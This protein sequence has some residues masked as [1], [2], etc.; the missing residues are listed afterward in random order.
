MA[1]VTTITVAQTAARGMN[2]FT[3][4]KDALS[5]ETIDCLRTLLGQAERGE[6]VGIA[7]AVMYRK[8]GYHVDTA[9]EAHRSMT[10]SRGM[11]RALD[12]KISRRL[13]A[14]R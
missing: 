10:Y 14:A 6:A 7:Y 8:S 12:D 11:L 4:V 3:L 2:P 1:K 13:H 9:G 5:H